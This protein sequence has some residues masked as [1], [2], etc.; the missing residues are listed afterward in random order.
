MTRAD[1][2]NRPP[3]LAYTARPYVIAKF[4]VALKAWNPEYTVEVE[5]V[6]DP[7]DPMPT[8]PLWRLWAWVS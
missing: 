8:E 4:L 6:Q 3:T 7:D 5:S 2:G 1:I